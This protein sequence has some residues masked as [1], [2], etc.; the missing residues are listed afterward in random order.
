[1]ALGR[2]LRARG[3]DVV[4]ETWERW[5]PYAEGE[6]L[7]FA[8]SPEYHVFPT[9]ERPLKPYEA[10]AR[11]AVHTRELVR[12]ERPD[13]VVADILTLAP[14][15]A[16]ELE[17]V[18]VA[19]VVPHVD[20]RSAPGFPPYS[21]GVRLPR[22]AAGR[23]VWDAAARAMAAGLEHGRVELNETR[24]RLG[25]PP[26]ARVHGGISDQLCLVATFPQLEYPR[27]GAGEPAT[28]VVGPLQWEPPFEA[29]ELPPGDDP[30]VLVAPSTSQDRD[31][32]MLRAALTG[33]ADLPIRVL[34]TY[35]RRLPP[36]PLRVPANAR[37]VEWV[38]Y[39]RTM[40]HCDAVVCHAGHG[41]VVRALSSGCVVVACPAAGDMNE[42]AARVDWASA[43]VRLP[44]RLVSSPAAVR[45]AVQRAL[46]E[47]RFREQA[48]ELAAWSATHDAGARAAELVERLAAAGAPREPPAAPRA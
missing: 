4:L 21:A 24:R 46:G 35:N 30:L 34:A 16:G 45:L 5:R 13:V 37:L 44:R 7:R 28:H 14:A 9:R 41:T 25:L 23:A 6:G 31:H 33:L 8:A 2:A 12:A 43:G 19:T 40:P 32:A 42:N 10:V 26:Q 3:H 27:P 39:A 11:A 47:P 38:S 17:G 29:V 20:P 15:L 22:T 36:V 48:R 1:M 18:P